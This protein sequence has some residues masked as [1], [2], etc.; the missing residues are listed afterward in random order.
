M[1]A[2]QKRGPRGDGCETGG[3]VGGVGQEAVGVVHGAEDV[4]YVA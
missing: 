3:A 1:S 2:E 4:V